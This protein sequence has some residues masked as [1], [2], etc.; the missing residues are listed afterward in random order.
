MAASSSYIVARRGET[1]ALAAARPMR[2]ISSNFT[3]GARKHVPEKLGA[4][5]GNRVLS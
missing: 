5:L 2:G 4:A 1:A 3:Y